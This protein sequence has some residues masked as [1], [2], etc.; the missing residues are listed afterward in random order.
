MF[1]IV[2]LVQFFILP[3]DGECVLDKVV[4]SDAEEIHLFREVFA[5]DRCRR[6]LDHDADRHIA[7]RN[8]LFLQLIP[9]GSGD[10]LRLF[11]LPEGRNHWEHDRDLPEGTRAVDCPK[12]RPEDLRSCQAD[13]DRA[14]SHRRVLFFL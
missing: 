13:P 14:V 7:E 5:D 11:Y 1:R 3:V 10:L 12:L 9:D 6:G 4:R 8:S 2:K